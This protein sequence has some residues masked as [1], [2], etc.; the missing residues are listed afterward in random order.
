[1][2]S[3]YH[4]CKLLLPSTSVLYQE[5]II[6]TS[7]FH[8]TSIILIS[9]D[10]MGPLVRLYLIMVIENRRLNGAALTHTSA[11]WWTI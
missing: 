5:V 9:V 7:Y 10:S 6:N 1:M 3:D 8:T 2:T 11:F 4:I